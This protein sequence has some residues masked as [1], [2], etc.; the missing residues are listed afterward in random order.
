MFRACARFLMAVSVSL[1]SILS[2]G[3][4][5]QTSSCPTSFSPPL[6]NPT[7]SKKLI[8]LVPQV[9]GPGGL[10]GANNGG[11]LLSTEGFRIGA[12]EVHFQSSSAESLGPLNEEI[13]TQL[14]QLPLASTVSGFVF[15]FNPGLGVVARSSESFGPILTERADT[16]GKHKLFVGFS[17]QYFDF[18]R[19]DGVNLSVCRQNL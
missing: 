15:S 5:A 4:S 19:A 1:A 17:Y 8:C 13:G 10:V 6:P 11:P 3:S 7:F 2:I 9:Y 16:I 18:D 12:H 14:S